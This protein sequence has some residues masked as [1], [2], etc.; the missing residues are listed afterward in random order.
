MCRFTFKYSCLCMEIV[1]G[2]G[3]AP[4]HKE[5]ESEGRTDMR[6]NWRE[7]GSAGKERHKQSG[8][9]RSHP[10]EERHHDVRY[11]DSSTVLSAG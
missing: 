8:L 9:G 10:S 3:Q 5:G 6:H 7:Y 11:S 2:S 1:P 4:R